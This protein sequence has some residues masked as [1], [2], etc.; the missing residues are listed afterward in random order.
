MTFKA[1]KNVNN[2]FLKKLKPSNS[3]MDQTNLQ[4]NHTEQQITLTLVKLNIMT[5]CIEMCCKADYCPNFVPPLSEINVYE[6]I[7]MISY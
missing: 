7:I 1:V 2:V 5:Y 6:D 4:S 3:E